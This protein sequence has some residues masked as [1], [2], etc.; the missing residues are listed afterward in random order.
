MLFQCGGV[1]S[2]RK[3]ASNPRRGGSACLWPPVVSFTGCQLRPVVVAP[4]GMTFSMEM[5]LGEAL[6]SAGVTRAA[7]LNPS[8][9]NQWPRQVCQEVFL[10]LRKPV[11][12]EREAYSFRVL[13]PSV[14]NPCSTPLCLHPNHA[15]RKNVLTSP[16]S[17][18][19]R[20]QGRV[21]GQRQH[22][23]A[24]SPCVFGQHP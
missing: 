1:Q 15:L 24:K 13:A 2:S 8:S 10:L 17:E 5:R 11:R 18:A 7:F 9:S 12:A 16:S 20:P 14:W 21:N 23:A 4:V 6:K 3:G 19:T 22:T